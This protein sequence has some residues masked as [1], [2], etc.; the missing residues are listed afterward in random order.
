[1][2]ER[3]RWGNK[4]GQDSGLRWDVLIA[5]YK[6]FEAMRIFLK[7]STRPILCILEWIRLDNC[8]SIKGSIV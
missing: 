2:N 8:S 6:L 7:T 4:S 5:Y 3:F 1:M